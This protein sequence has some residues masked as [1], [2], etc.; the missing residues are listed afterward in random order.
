MNH[1]TKKGEFD[2][3]IIVATAV[4]LLVAGYDTTGTT[5]AYACYQ[6]AKNPEVQERLREEIVDIHGGDL[7]EE[8]TYDDLH[9]M[10]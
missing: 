4:V 10:I 6:L 3:L 2:K 8:I 1:V 5:M 7:S 9:D